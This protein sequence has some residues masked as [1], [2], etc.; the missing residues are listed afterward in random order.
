MTG[1]VNFDSKFLLK[2]IPTDDILHYK[3]VYLIRLSHASGRYK[4]IL[5]QAQ[6]TNVSLDGK[7]QQVIGVH[8]DISYLPIPFDHKISFISN[9]RPS[10]FSILPDISMEL[11]NDS[12]SSLFTS[13]EILVLKHLAEGKNFNQI[14]NL[15]G[16]SPHTINTHKKNILKKSYSNSMTELVAKCIR[17][18]I[19]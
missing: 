6:T 15:L 9:K 4:T 7:L 1:S 16:V 18:G 10:Y 13:K 8:T 5:H 14:A 11:L 2:T 17:A 3:V 12:L 19:I